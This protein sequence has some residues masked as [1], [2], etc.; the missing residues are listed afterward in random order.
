MSELVLR[1]TRANRADEYLE[2]EGIDD[3]GD[4]LITVRDGHVE[5][6]TYLNASQLKTL[7]DR[8]DEM[9]EATQ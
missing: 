5:S 1:L 7:R 9:L 6:A 2:I 3:E 4:S 8:I